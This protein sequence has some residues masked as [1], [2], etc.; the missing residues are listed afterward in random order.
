[1]DIEKLRVALNTASDSIP[2][3]VYRQLVIDV[4]DALDPEDRVDFAMSCGIVSHEL[5][6]VA[7]GRVL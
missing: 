2:V 7:S 3:G 1:M 6:E 4:A 5:V